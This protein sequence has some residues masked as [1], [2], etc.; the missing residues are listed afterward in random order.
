MS[1]KAAIFNKTILK[2]QSLFRSFIVFSSF[3]SF[4]EFIIST[5]KISAKLFNNE[6]E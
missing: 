3:Y 4:A 2:A 5:L 6:L 1:T